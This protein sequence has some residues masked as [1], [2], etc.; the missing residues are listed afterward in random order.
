MV[1]ITVIFG[2]LAVAGI[3]TSVYLFAV[4]DFDARLVVDPAVEPERESVDPMETIPP[5]VPDGETSFEDV[6]N[7][8]WTRAPII[9]NGRI[10][11]RQTNKVAQSAL[12]Q[13]PVD[14]KAFI[15]DDDAIV[16]NLIWSKRLDVYDPVTR[17]LDW[18]ATMSSI[19]NYVCNGI[20]LPGTKFERPVMEYVS[21]LDEN[22]TYE[23]W[24]FPF[25]TIESMRGD[26][27]D[28]AILIASL[29]INAG[30]PAYRVKVAA[31]DV[32]NRRYLEDAG[33]DVQSN[34]SE[35]GHAYC[36]Y[37][38]SDDEWR[39][40][41]WCYYADPDTP[42]LQKPLAKNGGFGGC[43]GDVWFTFNN[44]YSW[45]QTAIDV[46]GRIAQAK[47]A[48]FVSIRDEGSVRE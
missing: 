29:A 18:D 33:F 13:T 9:Y 23:F 32:S 16:R 8:R 37:L 44:E 4:R 12:L 34:L 5:V 2:V 38:A 43:Y 41:D 31:G 48:P 27:E 19:Q 42:V 46:T 14:V 25:E 28:G 20:Y 17:H 36:I 1:V 22:D 21:D 30:I 15:F 47:K 3:A 26:C 6:V 45:N 40:I 7:G 35:G 11:K 24:Q 10:L 39:I